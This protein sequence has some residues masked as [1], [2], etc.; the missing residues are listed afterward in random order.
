MAHLHLLLTIGVPLI[1]SEHYVTNI[2]FLLCL[3]ATVY[4]GVAIYAATEF[5]SQ[6]SSASLDFH[7]PVSVLKP[8]C[9]LDDGA[10]ENL[11][12]FCQQD[13]PS[14]QIIFGVQDSQDPS[15]GV[16]KQI[17]RDFPEQDICLVISDRVIGVNYK[18]CNL[19]NALLEAKHE[20][21]VLADSDIRVKPHYLKR[22]VQPLKNPNVGI[23][24]CMYRSLTKGWL[25]AFEALGIT[26][27]FLPGVLVARK[28]EG[29]TFA[30]GASIAIRRSV[31]DK[32]GG[33]SAI[34]NYLEDDYKLG[35]SLFQA[36]YQIV[37]SDHVVDHAME[38]SSLAAFIHHQTR[39]ARGIRFARPLGH[40]GLIFTY[41]IVS[42]FLFLLAT[43]GSHFGWAV[44]MITWISRLF[45]A[46]LVSIKYLKDSVARK[47]LWLVPLR[48]FM[49]FAVWCYSFFGNTVQWRNHQFK[50]AKGGELVAYDLVES[51]GEATH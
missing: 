10:Y 12:S 41:G 2:L 11:A 9:G 31:L 48:D 33:F 5:F 30:M 18:V 38:T 22:I 49:S 17:I 16:V 36:G 1:S 21:L 24:T 51:L 46:W 25:A 26:T 28:L 37:L 4:Y 40:L 7:P 19:A 13:Y 20:I 43:G 6:P 50:L 45:L 42:S 32:I 3:S 14:Y 35:N 34:A 29:M 23:V 44:L 39:W 27:E 15:I 47:S 8:L